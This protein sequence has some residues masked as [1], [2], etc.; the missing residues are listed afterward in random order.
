MSNVGRITHQFTA[1]SNFLKAYVTAIILRWLC[2][3]YS[4][5]GNKILY[6]VPVKS[7]VYTRAVRI[8]FFLTPLPDDH[9]MDSFAA[10]RARIGSFAMDGWFSSVNKPPD[11]YIVALQSHVL[12]WA[13]QVCCTVAIL[14]L[15]EAII[16]IFRGFWVISKQESL[17]G[18]I[19][20]GGGGQHGGTVQQCLPY[21][22]FTRGYVTILALCNIP[23]LPCCKR[24]QPCAFHKTIMANGARLAGGQPT[25]K[26]E[27]TPLNTE[28]QIVPVPLVPPMHAGGIGA[29]GKLCWKDRKGSKTIRV[30]QT[31]FRCLACQRDL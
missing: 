29:S 28:T 25:T 30:L 1:I 15:K 22:A 4:E 26:C 3:T 21:N 2:T 8:H 19:G 12:D 10:N 16:V 31:C 24:T 27:A 14:T 7:T 5:L 6:S 11:L 9:V 18:I 20:K 13:F 23:L 17:D